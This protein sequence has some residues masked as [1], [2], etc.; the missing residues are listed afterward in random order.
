[1][2]HD[3]CWHHHGFI[4]L[5]PTSDGNAIKAGRQVPEELPSEGSHDD[6]NKVWLGFLVADDQM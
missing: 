6:A 2:Q 5:H 3:I 4:D 1:L